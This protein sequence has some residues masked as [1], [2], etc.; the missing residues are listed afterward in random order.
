MTTQSIKDTRKEHYMYERLLNVVF[1]WNPND[2]SEESPV[3]GTR[4]SITPEII[5]KA[6]SKMASGNASGI[7]AEM[8]KP[9]G[10]AG[11][12]EV[13]DLIEDIISEGF[14]PTDWQEISQRVSSQL[15]GRRALFSICSRAKGML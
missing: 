10:E 11:A 9:F 8:L 14:M 6:I 13:R 5:T 1:P 2:L 15:T 3:E 4:E 7:V 12:G